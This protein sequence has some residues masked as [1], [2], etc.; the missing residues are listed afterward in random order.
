MPIRRNTPGD[1]MPHEFKH[2]MT[3]DYRYVAATP[4]SNSVMRRKIG[5]ILADDRIHYR[6]RDATHF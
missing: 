4:I 3:V 1:K 2:L 6:H 5:H